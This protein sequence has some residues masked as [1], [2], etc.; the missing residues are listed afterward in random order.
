MF[1]IHSKKKK[2]K[3]QKNKQNQN[4]NHKTPPN[5]TQAKSNKKTQPETLSKRVTPFQEE[6]TQPKTNT[7]CL[8]GPFFSP[9]HR[10]ERTLCIYCKMQYLAFL[11]MI[12]IFFSSYQ[13]EQTSQHIS[14][15]SFQAF[16]S[17][18]KPIHLRW[19]KK[20]MPQ[21]TQYKVNFWSLPYQITLHFFSYPARVTGVL[22]GSRCFSFRSVG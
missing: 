3:P 9:M 1:N 5:K 22:T 6:K 13:R 11:L 21:F 2:P 19:Q 18:K 10:V 20:K 4:K 17:R 12:F 15:F 8:S 14:S 7:L 16:T